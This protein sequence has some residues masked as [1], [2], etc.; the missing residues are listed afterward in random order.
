MKP[1]RLPQQMQNFRTGRGW[2]SGYAIGLSNLLQPELQIITAA[3]TAVFAQVKAVIPYV[4]LEIF[5][6]CSA[7]L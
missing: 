7:T 5:Y 1:C 3:N 6:R 2:G 4:S